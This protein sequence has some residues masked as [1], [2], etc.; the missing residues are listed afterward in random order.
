VSTLSALSGYRRCGC[1]EREPAVHV[2]LD[3]AVRGT[4]VQN[5]G[6]R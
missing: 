5:K 2:E 3:L 1:P 6:R 4:W